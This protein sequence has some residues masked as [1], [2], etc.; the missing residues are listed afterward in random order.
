MSL[1]VTFQGIN[2]FVLE[3]RIPGSDVGRLRF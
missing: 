1:M 3:K 2:S